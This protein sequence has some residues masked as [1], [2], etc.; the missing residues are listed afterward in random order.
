VYK[1]VFLLI[2]VVYNEFAERTANFVIQKAFKN[3]QIFVS[4]IAIAL[5]LLVA[6]SQLAIFGIFKADFSASVQT[7]I[8]QKRSLVS[9]F[10]PSLPDMEVTKQAQESYKLQVSLLNSQMPEQ[11]IFILQ[12]SVPIFDIRVVELSYSNVQILVGLD[13]Y[14]IKSGSLNRSRS[15]SAPI[16]AYAVL[17]IG[18]IG[19]FIAAK[20][21]L[22]KDKKNQLQTRRVFTLT[23][24][25]FP[26]LC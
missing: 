12:N 18:I 13:S 24:R 5:I 8:Y 15:S 9:L 6:I 7:Q 16:K 3:N 19:F 21:G 11:Q 26:M 23:P 14:F 22:K 2:K 25:V 1:G 4:V 20:F 17:P 10:S